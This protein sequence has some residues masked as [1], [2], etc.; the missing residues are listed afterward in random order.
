MTGFNVPILFLIYRQPV[1]TK[2]AFDSIK[3][4]KPNLLY[5]AA[6]GPNQDRPSDEEECE[7]TRSIINDIDWSCDVKKRFLPVNVGLKK[8]VS[9]AINWFFSEVNEGIIL[10]YDCVATDSFF[11]FCEAMLTRYR[12]DDQV[13]CVTGD[14]FQNG[15]WRGDGDYYFSNLFGCWGW[16]TWSRS[17]K[18]WKP[19]LPN[20]VLF[21][22]ENYIYSIV[23]TEKSRRYWISCF[24]SINNGMNS[25]TWAFCFLYAQLSRGSMCVVPNINLVSNIGFSNEGTHAKDINSPL[26]GIKS[27]ELYSYKEPT[28]KLPCIKADEL[29]TS[30]TSCQPIAV[31]AINK[32]RI[33]KKLWVIVIV[34]LIK[35]YFKMNLL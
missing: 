9:G 12:N 27:F 29:Q 13:F 35:K 3:K 23:Q 32:I 7:S 17:W 19:D 16:A 22:L 2:L 30:V 28:F 8:A 18:H 5:I 4:I 33:I 20:Y 26:A 14:N 24:D 34:P 10:E 25:S 11:Y 6:D 21:K 31:Q 15:K 1:V